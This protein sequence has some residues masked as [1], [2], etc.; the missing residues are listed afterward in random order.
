M[1]HPPNWKIKRRRKK[2]PLQELPE[3][4]SKHTIFLCKSCAD[5]G[6]AVMVDVGKTN[7]DAFSKG[8]ILFMCPT[9]ARCRPRYEDD[10]NGDPRDAWLPHYINEVRHAVDSGKLKL[11]RS[12]EPT[13]GVFKRRWNDYY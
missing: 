7:I 12:P 4:Y 13:D 1:G 2:A 6:F 11:I 5:E 9:C 8:S 3:Q 10:D